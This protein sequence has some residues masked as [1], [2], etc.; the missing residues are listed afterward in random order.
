MSDVCGHGCTGGV[1]YR[2]GVRVGYTGWVIRE[3]NTGYPATVRSGG[4]TAKRAQEGPQGLEWVVWLQRPQ[5]VRRRDGSCTHPS[6]PVGPAPLALPGAG[7]S[8]MP[9]LGQRAR[10]HDISMKVSQNDEVSPKSVHEASHSPYSQNGPQKSPLGILRFP[11][12]AAFSHKE[13]MGPF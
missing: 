11:F 2:E 4:Q 10:F 1:W 6:G 13:L 5:G 12:I 7:P 9:P 8:Q 3:G